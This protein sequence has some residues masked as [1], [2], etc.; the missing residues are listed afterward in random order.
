MAIYPFFLVSFFFLH[1]WK[2]R[3]HFFVYD[4]NLDRRHQLRMDKKRKGRNGDINTYIHV[5]IF[6]EGTVMIEITKRSVAGEI[7]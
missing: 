4:D 3:L 5:S 2:N 6:Q 7:G 1:Q